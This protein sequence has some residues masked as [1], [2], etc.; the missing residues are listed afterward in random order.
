MGQEDKKKVLFIG[1]IFYD[2]HTLIKEKIENFNS[3]VHFYPEKKYGLLF[4]ILNTLHAY[5]I[6]LS[7]KIHYLGILRAI[8][9]EKYTHLFVVRGEKMPIFAIKKIKEMNPGIRTFLYQW[10]SNKN[11]SYFHLV[12]YF[13]QVFTF[14]F[15]DYNE[16]KSLKFLQ[17]FYTD[18]IKK[19]SD[20]TNAE[21]YD[22]FLF[23]SSFE[24][25]IDQSSH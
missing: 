11:N 9:N 15:K 13:D 2:Y 6:V 18:D 22:Y 8:K 7:Q 14:D 5:F 21:K 17:L 12:P 23:F 4:G 20:E 3:E 1:P 19:I 24:V 16:N 25:I 10:D